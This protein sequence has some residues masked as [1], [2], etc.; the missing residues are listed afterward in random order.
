[1]T[2]QIQ[3]VLRRHALYGQ[4]RLLPALIDVQERSG[5]L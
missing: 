4:T 5:Y 3:E 2:G 1:M